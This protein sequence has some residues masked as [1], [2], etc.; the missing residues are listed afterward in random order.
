MMYSVYK[1]NKQTIY[2]LDVLLSNL[3]PIRC[4]MS[5]SNCCFLT[6]TQIPQEAG[7]LKNFPQIV[8]NHTRTFKGFG[9]V[10]KTEVDVF[11]ELSC[12]FHDPMDVGNLISGSSAFSI[13][14]LNFW[15]FMVHV[16]FETW[17]GEFWALLFQHVRWVQLCSS[18]NIL[19][20][21]L[22][23]RLEWKL[24]LSCGVCWVFQICWYIECST[25]TASSFR[26][27]NSSTGMPSPPLAL[28]VVMLSKA[29]LTSH[30]RMSGSRWVITSSRPR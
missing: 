23:L 12:F 18:L 3:E 25:F 28:F 5:C 30:S 16:L 8:A 10:N 1:L 21:C 29:H 22:S 15:N 19:W 7:F 24:F 13:S 6:Y 14:S 27:W 4:S 20:H 9:I 26:I 11:L 2:S 17:L